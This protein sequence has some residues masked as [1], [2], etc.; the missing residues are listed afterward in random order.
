MN[1]G[2]VGMGTIGRTV[3]RELDRERVPGIRLSALSSRDLPKARAF[4]TTLANAPRSVPL[5]EMP[6]LCDLVIE[7]AGAEAV[8][9]VAETAL[10]AGV[11]IMVLSCGVLLERQDLVEMAREKGAVIHVPSGAIIGLDGLRGAAM[12]QVEEV[13]IIT[14]KPPKGLAGAPGV[15]AAGVDLDAVTSP[16]VLYEGP[17]AEAVKLF[18]ANVNVAAA[19]SM[20]GVGPLRTSIRVIAD[21]EVTRNTH[22]VV[23]EGEFGRMELHIENVPTEE[24][25]RTG[26]LTALSVL[27]YLKQMVSPL[28]LGV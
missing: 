7:A 5:E 8:G 27:A 19:V 12:G 9:P 28:R 22:Q 14:R 15:A 23:A 11:S 24:N 3:A 13:T 20:A 17:V 25:P 21:P 10:A 16:T 4:A 1:V 26:R 2:I 18:P 6:A